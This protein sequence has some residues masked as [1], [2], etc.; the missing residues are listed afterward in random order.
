MSH[1]LS[2]FFPSSSVRRPPL[3]RPKT[4]KPTQ[5]NYSRETGTTPDFQYSS[6][7][8]SG[9]FF[10]SGTNRHVNIACATDM[11]A[12][13]AKVTDF[14]IWLKASGKKSTTTALAIHWESTGT[15][16]AVPR[17]WLG[18]ISGTRVQKTGP[19][20]EA[21]KAKYIKIRARTIPP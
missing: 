20:H 14:P 7:S 4:D 6:I 16:I 21:K 18:K 17:M 13:K 1:N 10:V 12:R 5:P 8:S 3:I 11:I 9:L 2:K 15:V 19:M